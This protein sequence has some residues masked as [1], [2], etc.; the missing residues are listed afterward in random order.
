MLDEQFSIKSEIEITHVQVKS[1]FFDNGELWALIEG[2]KGSSRNV[3][4]D[5]RWRHEEFPHMVSHYYYSN[6]LSEGEM[7]RGMPISIKHFNSRVH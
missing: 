7:Q 6:S 5:H 3:G 4:P 2:S 1:S